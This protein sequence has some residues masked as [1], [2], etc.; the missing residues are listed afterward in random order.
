MTIR[1]K[2]DDS[3]I[4]TISEMSRNDYLKTC[5][6]YCRACSRTYNCIK[7]V[8]AENEL[9][10]SFKEVWSKFDGNFKGVNSRG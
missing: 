10:S 6:L 5:R 4:I 3:M 9:S 8:L 7:F 2:Y 1:A